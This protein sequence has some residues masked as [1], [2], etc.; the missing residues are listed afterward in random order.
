MSNGK[1]MTLRELTE[2]LKRSHYNA[3]TYRDT[4]DKIGWGL[5]HMLYI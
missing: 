4:V 2:V 5:K 1:F 3:L